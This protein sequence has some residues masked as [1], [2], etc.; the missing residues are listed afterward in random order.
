MEGNIYTSHMSGCPYRRTFGTQ[1]RTL[2]D[3]GG[4]LALD[5]R[6]RFSEVNWWVV[7]LAIMLFV[8]FAV[9]LDLFF[10]WL[11]TYERGIR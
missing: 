4:E 9:A 2:R 11:E 6:R 1:R 3:R 7:V 5:A 8:L 10:N